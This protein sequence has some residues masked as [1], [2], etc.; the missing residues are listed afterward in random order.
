MTLN[1]TKTLSWKEYIENY[2]KWSE[3]TRCMYVSRLKDFGPSNE[4]AYIASDL[5]NI[6]SGSRL[7]NRAIDAGIRFM[8][9]DIELVE[10]SVNE[11]TLKRMRQNLNTRAIKKANGNAFWQGVAGVYLTDVIVDDLLKRKRI[12]LH[13]R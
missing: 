6:T 1:I 13:W 11:Q 8:P 3:K 12:S 4:V 9:E 7:I 2:D 10:F 5:F